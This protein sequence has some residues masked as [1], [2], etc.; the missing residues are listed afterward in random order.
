MLHYK[1]KEEYAHLKDCF[2]L[3]DGQIFKI[4][5]VLL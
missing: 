4:I 1:T 5:N 2:L 3:T